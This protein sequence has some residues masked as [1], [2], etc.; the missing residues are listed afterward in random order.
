MPQHRR[1]EPGLPQRGGGGHQRV[2]RGRRQRRERGARARPAER[3][4]RL[5]VPP[6]GGQRFDPR[7]EGGERGGAQLPPPPRVVV[8]GDAGLLLLRWRETRARL[9]GFSPRRRRRRR[10]GGGGGGGGGLGE[11]GMGGVEEAGVAECGELRL[12][13]WG[14][15]VEFDGIMRKFVQK[16]GEFEVKF[17]GL[18]GVLGWVW[19]IGV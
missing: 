18:G 12:H 17:A 4:A 6:L 3:V 8:V 9:E 2:V 10:R 14:G 5:V 1:G 16:W 15:E 19:W 7:A 13:G 11:E